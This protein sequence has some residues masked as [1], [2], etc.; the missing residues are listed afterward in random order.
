MAYDLKIAECVLAMHQFMQIELFQ[1]RQ[2]ESTKMNSLNTLQN[3]NM[4]AISSAKFE[5]EFCRELP[6]SLVDLSNYIYEDGELNQY[7]WMP[8]FEEDIRVNQVQN[9]IMAEAAEGE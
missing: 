4:L 1:L 3:G 2:E 7:S 8:P 5:K 9:E 6:D